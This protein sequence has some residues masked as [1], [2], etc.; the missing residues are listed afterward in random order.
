MN[1]SH[2]LRGALQLRL[3]FWSLHGIQRLLPAC[4][5]K[6]KES[7]SVT[8]MLKGGQPCVLVKFSTLWLKLTIYIYRE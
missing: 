4:P 3:H 2:A 5:V 6:M 8:N 1:I 7:G